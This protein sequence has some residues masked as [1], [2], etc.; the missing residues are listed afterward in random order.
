MVK[1]MVL[2]VVF[3]FG[4]TLI[5]FPVVAGEKV[6]LEIYSA[7]K[8]RTAPHMYTLTLAKMLNDLHPRLNGSGLECMGTIDMVATM[9][10]LPP[11]RRKNAF[12][13]IQCLGRIKLKPIGIRDPGSAIVAKG[14]I[15]RDKILPVSFRGAI[16]LKVAVPVALT[17][18]PEDD[19]VPFGF[20]FIQTA[21]MDTPIA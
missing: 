19:V 14:C 12:G 6:E 1:K 20:R 13:I 17:K 18:K 8:A 11:E 7:A 4:L 2:A 10:K 3:V 5:A 15:V 21:E 16:K 9:D